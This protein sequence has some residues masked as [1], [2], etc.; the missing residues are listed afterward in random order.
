MINPFE[1][2]IEDGV[3]SAKLS[4]D[5]TIEG[6]ISID[7]SAFNNSIKMAVITSG[8]YTGDGTSNKAIPHGLGVRPKIVQITKGPFLYYMSEGYIM[9]L[10]PAADNTIVTDMDD[11][12]FYVGVSGDAVNTANDN[13]EVY[14]WTAIV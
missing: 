3:V 14:I 11:T 13:T 10:N 6:G 12:N 8:S 9:R 5:L 4:G 7:G 2:S 1:I